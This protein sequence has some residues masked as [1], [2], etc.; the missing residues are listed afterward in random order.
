[1]MKIVSY[2]FSLVLF[3]CINSTVNASLVG[4]Y[5]VFNEFTQLY[6]QYGGDKYMIDEDITQRSHVLQAAHFSR[7][8]GAPEN[9]VIGLLLHD[10]GQIVD[11][12]K[13]GQTE[14]LHHDHDTLG[15]QWAKEKGFPEQVVQWIGFHTLAKLVLCDQDNEYYAHLSSASKKSYEIQRDK[16]SK[17]HP[18]AVDAFLSSRYLMDHLTARRCDDMAKQVAFDAKEDD[19]DGILPGFNSY[20][21]MFV[22][23]LEGK[24]RP[25]TNVRWRE[26]IHLLQEGM[27]EAPDEFLHH[28][29]IHTAKHFP[30]EQSEVARLATMD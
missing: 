21:A 13:V 14:T 16:Y 7:M 4:A 5:A 28:A 29:K 2:F 18:E 25:A 24:G 12:S 15:A 22:R 11:Q 23:V 26:A 27:W 17:E 30:Q 1:M 8:A 9:V 3:F 6:Q 10:V 19:P 20:E